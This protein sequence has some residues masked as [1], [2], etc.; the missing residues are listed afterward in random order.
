MTET[1]ADKRWKGTNAIGKFAAVRIS[2]GT[3]RVR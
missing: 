3:W 2:L 1:D